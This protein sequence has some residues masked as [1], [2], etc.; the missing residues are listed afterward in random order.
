MQRA[1]ER[2]AI[3]ELLALGFSY[4]EKEAL[5]RLGV[6][7]D[8]EGLGAALAQTNPEQLADEYLRLFG[9]AVA[10]PPHETEYEANPFTKARQMADINGFYRA[11]GFQVAEARKVLPDYIG[12]EL[13]FMSLLCRKEAY[14]L[15]QGWPDKAAVCADAE[16][17][18]LQEHL[19]RWIGLFS[20]KMQE[21]LSEGS[22]MNH[23]RTFYRT[24]AGLTERFVESEL[25]LWGLAPVYLTGGQMSSP[26][27]AQPMV[28]GLCPLNE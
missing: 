26:S 18:F 20:R 10:C 24:L 21:A 7:L 11:F 19:G 2:S 6:I 12:T 22:V 4:P 17:K 8:L 27:D 9:G 14:A 25:A 5:A 15:A 1:L 16:R 3:Y 28:C 13:E 23:A